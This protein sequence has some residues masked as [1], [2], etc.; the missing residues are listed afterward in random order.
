MQAPDLG[1]MVCIAIRNAVVSSRE[2][3]KKRGSNPF[4]PAAGA[5]REQPKGDL[6]LKQIHRGD[7]KAMKVLG[8]GQ[9]GEVYLAIQSAKRAVEERRKERKKREKSKII[10][11]GLQSS[12]KRDDD[13][14]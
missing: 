10:E 7:L 3:Q 11:V 8:A 13:T 6:A 1:Q 14:T 9:F 4:Q 12:R 2:S 5:E